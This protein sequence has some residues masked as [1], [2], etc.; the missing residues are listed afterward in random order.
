M[1][2]LDNLM[3]MVGELVI[4]QSQLS[5]DPNVIGSENDK[6]LE[7]ISHLEKITRDIQ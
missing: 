1:D 4:A 5:Q 2:K 7:K 3:N 6:L